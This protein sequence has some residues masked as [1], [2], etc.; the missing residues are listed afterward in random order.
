MITHALFELS[1]VLADPIRMQ[2][3]YPAH[4]GAVMAAR[5]G[6]TPDVWVNAYVQVRDD[7]DSY[8]RDL[9]LKGDEP[10]PDLWE[11]LFRTT[12][13]LFRLAGIAEPDKDELIAFSRVL[14]GLVYERFDGFYPQARAVL[15]QLREDGVSLHIAT[16]WTT[17]MAR[18]LLKGGGLS[19]YFS[20]PIIGIDVTESFDKD[21]AVLALK[22][23]AAPEASLIVDSDSISLERAR[24]AGMQTALIQD[25]D[26][27]TAIA[28]VRTKP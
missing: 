26:D 15:E 12:R 16:H 1:G 28:A 24:S 6:G 20:E 25:A 2:A 10:L 17:S 27:L 5:Y 3:N 7:W 4:L 14:Q 11:G 23:N 18:G 22:V 13:A 21:Y 9:N 8:W 19:A